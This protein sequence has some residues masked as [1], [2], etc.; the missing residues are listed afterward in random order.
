MTYKHR[1][2]VTLGTVSIHTQPCPWGMVFQKRKLLCQC[3]GKREIK[4]K[5]GE[6]LYEGR[7]YNYR[8]LTIDVAL[9]A[10]SIKESSRG[11]S[12]IKGEKCKKLIFL[13]IKFRVFSSGCTSF[14]GEPVHCMDLYWTVV[15]FA[16]FSLMHHMEVNDSKTILQG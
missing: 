13:N 5:R 4:G 10:I 12:H 2:I 3:E 16:L 11:R 14:P 1:R 9:N 7:W 15:C 8:R 6:R